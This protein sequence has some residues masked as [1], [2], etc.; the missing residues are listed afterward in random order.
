MEINRFFYCS[1]MAVLLISGFMFPVMVGSL[2]IN[3]GQ[4]GN[5]LPTPETVVPL[6]KAIGATKVKL[7][8][9]NPRILKAFANTGVE[10]I[11]ML[12]N[13][14]LSA[15]RD[16]KEAQDWVKQN[17]QAYLP[18]T[19]I[20]CISAGNEILTYNDTSLSN[21]LL[22]AM[23]SMQSALVTLGL[24]KQVTITTTHSLAIL[25]TSYPPSAGA[26]RR[27]LVGPVTKILD[28]HLKTGSPF[29]INAYPYFA[30]KN[31]PKQVSLDFVLFQP[32]QGVL[33]PTS[34]L[35][36]DNMLFAQIDAVYSAL[37]SL[38][39]KNLT[40]DISE[41]GW[42]SKGDEDEAGATPEYAKKYNGNL[43]KVISQKKGTPMKPDC[44]LNI[45]VFALFNENMKPGPTSE[46]NYGLFKPDGTPV[47]NLGI[48]TASVVS[49]NTSTGGSSGGNGGGGGG[50][51]NVNSGTPQP[52]NGYLSITSDSEKCGPVASLLFLIS[53]WT[54][55]LVCLPFW[56]VLSI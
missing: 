1:S 33:D 22:P 48:S 26:V 6:V 9:T 54:L 13:E 17:V 45:Y 46:R 14:C 56:G 19:K 3:Y 34:N 24:D 8:D 18:A 5:N 25:E 21:H 43:L 36:Y 16:P 30:Y 50:G 10:F 42:P 20:T 53:C 38:G 49:S 27:D 4:V 28:F 51:V 7:Y 37:A 29:L 55:C 12:P 35:H 39:Y 11:V 44:D 23:Q 41:T 52:P 40:V 47:Y 32:N 15:M 2:G 31:N